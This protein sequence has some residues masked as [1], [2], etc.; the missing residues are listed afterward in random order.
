[1]GHSKLLP[2]NFPPVAK[3]GILGML[4]GA[5]G[6]GG[7]VPF[8]QKLAEADLSGGASNT[9]SSGTFTAKQNLWVK[10]YLTA[11]GGNI[12]AGIRMDG[13]STSSYSR[14][15]QT[16]GASASTGTS[17]SSILAQGGTPT[18]PVYID[19]FIFNN[20]D[21][22]KLVIGSTCGQNTATSSNAP[23]RFQFAGKY[24]QT[25]AQITS[26]SLENFGSGN[27]GTGSN[28]V[29][30]GYNNDDTSGTSVWEELASVDLTSP[31]SNLDSGQLT[32]T[33]K[34]L[35]IQGSYDVTSANGVGLI[36]Y[37]IGGSYT[38]ITGA[39]RYAQD[40]GA[41]GTQTGVG[42]GIVAPNSDGSSQQYV[43]SFIY[44]D[45][46]EEKLGIAS[47]TDSTTSGSSTANNR[48]E[49]VFKCTNTSGQLD[50]FRFS[51]ANGSN[52]DD[53]KLRIWGFD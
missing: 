20:A 37:G 6:G 50:I 33:K 42:Y 52:L 47:G 27:F 19:F 11:T 15:S 25:S 44:N 10:V 43:T 16:N 28:I 49:A 29:V 8:W 39:N 41:D 30:L 38:G 51:T 40:G 36:S 24:A 35:W 32:T 18:T 26:V 14:I 12:Q 21:N 2:M 31:S 13:I 4:A 1:M 48:T 17:N 23:N 7:A 9:L 5:G 3:G 46:D 45:G 22:E 53:G 34:Y